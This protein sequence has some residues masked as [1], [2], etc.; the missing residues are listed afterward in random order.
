MPQ[1]NTV[2]EETTS[3]ETETKTISGES[4]DGATDGDHENAGGSKSDE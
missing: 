4:A 3:T 1:G 2:V